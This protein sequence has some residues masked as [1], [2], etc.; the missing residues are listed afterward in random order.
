[1]SELNTAF[2]RLLLDP[3]ARARLSSD[4]EAG[5]W[6]ARTTAILASVDQKDLD[7]LGRAMFRGVSSGDLLGANLEDAFRSTLACFPASHDQDRTEQ[8]DDTI[9]TFMASPEFRNVRTVGNTDG[10]PVAQAFYDWV[11]R[12]VH[13]PV[14]RGTAQREYA[15]T[16]LRVLATTAVPY[17]SSVENFIR[18]SKAGWIAVLDQHA[19]LPH[20][21]AEPHSPL[22]MG[23]S[24]GRYWQGPVGRDV[25][26][27]MLR[28]SH[29]PPGWT[30]SLDDARCAAV[31]AE[32]SA[33]GL[34]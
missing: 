28:S 15:R 16:T 7:K 34:L 10:L 23:V 17:F 19:E 9:A 27:A 22:A 20:A 8:N 21:D 3:G 4:L 30:R 29:N 1:M 24:R 25:A 14:I 13:E 5:L 33:R 32:L 31:S 26:G 12:S 11:R 2:H 6:S 18:S